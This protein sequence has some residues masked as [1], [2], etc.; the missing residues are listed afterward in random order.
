MIQGCAAG[1]GRRC[2]SGAANGC[3]GGRSS[4]SDSRVVGCS[5]GA[6]P[7][8]R[9]ARPRE[10]CTGLASGRWRAERPARSGRSAAAR[11]AAAPRRRSRRAAR[12]AGARLLLSLRRQR[13]RSLR[14]DD[15][16]TRG[17]N[18]SPC[19]GAAE[20][21]P[22]L[23]HSSRRSWLQAP[24]SAWPSRQHLSV[25]EVH[26]PVLALQRAHRKQP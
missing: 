24:S 8:R 6:V 5:P 19:S 17:V 2:P 1:V 13:L 25:G 20:R 22:A 18:R 26:K 10:I 16:C 14:G 23:R 3:S 7:G 21:S 4:A 11:S 12:A 9:T 15:P